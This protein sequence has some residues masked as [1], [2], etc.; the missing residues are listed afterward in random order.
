MQ[1]R[2]MLKAAA[3]SGL[4]L[5][6]N[7]ALAAE[8]RRKAVADVQTRDGARLFVRDWGAGEPVVF[9]HGWALAS[10][11]WAYQMAPMAADGLR[12]VA[13][14]RR[15]HGR[16]SDPGRGYDFDTLAGD[17]EAALAALDLKDVTL[18]GH[19]L[20]SGEMVR[21]LTNY[22]SRRISRLVFLAPAA[23]PGLAKSA[24]NPN[25]IE[26]EFFENVRRNQ[27]MQDFPKWIDDNAPPFFT[28]ET[29]PGILDWTR[30]MMIQTSMQAVI[31]CN[32]AMTEANFR[33]EL[34]R[35]DV[36]SL[37]IHG[38]KDVSAPVEMTG[39]PTAALIP[40]AE[41]ALYQGAPHGLYYTHRARLV[42]DLT[43]FIR[44]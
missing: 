5:V 12:C 11:M 14:D 44:G 25:G 16:S 26:P 34:R 32:R 40:G 7:A 41:L 21:Y 28:T 42:A 17:L 9:L 1:R 30:R 43:R 22:G 6:G 23:T 2:D 27:L 15:G 10:D 37:V 33:D 19:S 18:V 13:F 8:P 29:S 39:A 38:T 4:T 35:I 24:D 20:A 3:A 36:P 31:D